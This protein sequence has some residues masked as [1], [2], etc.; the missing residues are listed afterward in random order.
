MMLISPPAAAHVGSELY[1]T[2]RPPVSTRSAALKRLN[3]VAHRVHHA[4]SCFYVL[5]V[6]PKKMHDLEDN[7]IAVVSNLVPSIIK[8]LL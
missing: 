5:G 6:A 8:F 2:P 4:F 3:L 1:I 7:K